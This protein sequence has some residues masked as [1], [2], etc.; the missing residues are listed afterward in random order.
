MSRF[1]FKASKIAFVLAAVLLTACLFPFAASAASE[2]DPKNAGYYITAFDV[3]VN[4]TEGNVY[5]VTEKID[6]MFTE[7]SQ[8]IFVNIPQW[9]EM[10]LPEAKHSLYYAPVKTSARPPKPIPIRK[11]TISIS[12]SALRAC[13]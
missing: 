13:I 8:G 7:R 9:V 1:N 10:A 3:S 2:L 12:G 11:T 5:Q 6:V 4:V